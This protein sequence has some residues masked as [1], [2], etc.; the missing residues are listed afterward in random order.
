MYCHHFQSSIRECQEEERKGRTGEISFFVE[1]EMQ[2]H[3]NSLEQIS[4]WTPSL[5]DG[6]LGGEGGTPFGLSSLQPCL[7]LCQN[8][9]LFHP[10]CRRALLLSVHGNAGLEAALSTCHCPH[11]A[12]LP[13]WWHSFKMRLRGFLK[14]QLPE[15]QHSNRLFAQEPLSRRMSSTK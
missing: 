7:N 10:N 11:P 15:L 13:Q 14:T 5:T 4:S 3:R 12:F 1:E 8:Q 2:E 6:L 9:E